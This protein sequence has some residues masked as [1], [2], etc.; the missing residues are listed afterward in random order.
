MKFRIQNLLD[1]ELEITQNDT[2]VL[3]QKYG[4]TAKIDVKW[5]LGN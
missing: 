5:D 1:E 2:V 4:T 3:A